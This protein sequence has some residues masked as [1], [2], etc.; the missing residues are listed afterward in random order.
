MSVT[1]VVGGQFGSEGKGK[2]C[3][4]LAVTDQ[5]DYMVRCGGPIRGIPC[6]LM[7]TGTNCGKSL[8]GSLTRAYAFLIAPGALVDP[9]VFL[10][11]SI[12]A[13]WTRIDWHRRKRWRH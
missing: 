6:M 9:E 8:R 7:G 2:I 4:H 13:G 12:S 1:V 10:G 11:R 3:A 5:V